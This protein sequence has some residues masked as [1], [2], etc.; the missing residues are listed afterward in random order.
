M[1]D[2]GID[3]NDDVVNCGGH[4]AKTCQECPQGLGRFWCNGECLWW[5]NQ[6]QAQTIFITTPKNPPPSDCDH[7]GD[8]FQ[9]WISCLK[10]LDGR[11]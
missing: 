8:D 2:N 6:C 9:C 7:C 4:T 11:Q 1:I 10:Q 5:N 3:G